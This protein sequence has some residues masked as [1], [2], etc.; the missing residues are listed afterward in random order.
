M[1][2]QKDQFALGI[3]FVAAVGL[4]AAVLPWLGA[5]AGQGD[6]EPVFDLVVD[7][8]EVPAFALAGEQVRVVAEVF[9]TQDGEPIEPAQFSR[10]DRLVLSRDR[11]VDAGD[12]VLFDREMPGADQ[13]L[14]VTATLPPDPTLPDEADGPYWLIYQADANEQAPDAGR[15]NNTHLAPIYIDG[16]QRPELSVDRFD[17]PEQASVGGAIFID[18]AV[19][20]IGQG[21]ASTATADAPDRRPHWQDAIILSDDA[22]VDG[23]DRVLRTFDR[24]TPLGPD[25]SYRH[26]RVQLEIPIGTTGTMYLIAMADAGQQLDQPG[27]TAGTVVRRIE[28]VQ[29][30]RPD[31]VVASITDPNRLVIGR[32]SPVTFSIANL[33]AV[34]TLTGDWIDG[35]YLAKQPVLDD[36]A[37]PIAQAPAGQPLLPRARYQSTATVTLPRVEPGQWF[38]I[39]KADADETIDE[40]GLDHNNTLAIPIMVLTQEQADAEIKLGDPDRPERL[41]VQWIE[42]DRLEEHVARFSRTVQPALQAK[43]DPV[44]NAPL[45]TDPKPPTVASKDNRAAGDPSNPF[46]TVADLN[47]QD[48]R[49]APAPS[50]ASQTDVAPRPQTPG[51]RTPQKID[52]IA[53]DDGS[54]NKEQDGID[55]PL[56]KIKPGPIDPTPA[57]QDTPTPSPGDRLVESLQDPTAPNTDSTTDS[58]TP[59][60]I[61]TDTDSENPDDTDTDKPTEQ[62]KETD[63]DTPKEPD[64]D[65]PSKNDGDGNDE[66]KEDQSTTDKPAE[67]D[68]DKPDGDEGEPANPSEEQTPTRTP[69]DDSEAPPTNNRKVE[70]ALQ[71]GKVLVGEGIKVTVK[72]P[73]RPGTGARRLSL[74]RNARVSVTFDKTGKVYDA[75]ILRSTTYKEWDQAIESSLFNWSA[76]GKAIDTAQP[77]I[78]VEWNYLLNDLFDEDQ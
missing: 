3:A 38:L 17:T 30:G 7:S 67:S 75:K 44:P 19:V 68:T 51:S 25:A 21:W 32:P 74:P 12:A 52:G 37:M 23:S 28:L 36:R 11:V 65:E 1:R 9:E 5:E 41:V 59:S 71:E 45:I 60:E 2:P 77:Y 48:T 72:L 6:A 57:D 27:F 54:V 22:K 53:G 10:T 56:P 50:D 35:L 70:V 64:V 78:T 29:S 31:L 24:S 33:G 42:H 69:R 73:I 16:P 14:S 26:D 61:E 43:A 66:E 46:R 58:N 8:L 40:N 34:P 76:K 39:V 55:R 15:A 63:A 47:Q 49:P 20:N 62:L 18:F 13:G 4:H